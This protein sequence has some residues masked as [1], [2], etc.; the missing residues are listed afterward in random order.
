M[1][2]ITC[3]F[4]VVHY[5]FVSLMRSVHALNYCLQDV[6]GNQVPIVDVVALFI[7]HLLSI[8]TVIKIDTTAKEIIPFLKMH[9]LFRVQNICLTCNISVRLWSCKIKSQSAN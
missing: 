8:P 6:R 4:I 3:F 1:V 5:C 2:A 9:A 7:S